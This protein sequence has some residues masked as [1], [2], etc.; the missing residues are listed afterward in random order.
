MDNLWADGSKMAPFDQPFYLM[1]NVAVGGAV[2]DEQGV[3]SQ[4]LCQAHSNG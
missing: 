4:A 3:S 1:M 2:G